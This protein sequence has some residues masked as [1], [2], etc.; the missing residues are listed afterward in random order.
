M[1]PREVKG[2]RDTYRGTV[3]TLRPAMGV[4]HRADG[5]SRK[6]Q[7]LGKL[8]LGGWTGTLILACLLIACTRP[9]EYVVQRKDLVQ[10][11]YAAGEVVPVNFYGISS[12]IAGIVDSIYVAAG[13]EVA[14]GDTLLRVQTVSITHK[15]A[16]FFS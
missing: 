2:E 8:C 14:A 4:K 15:Y 5:G 9:E 13:E 7:V 3:K 1:A 16:Q 10:G 6:F 11:V 12:K